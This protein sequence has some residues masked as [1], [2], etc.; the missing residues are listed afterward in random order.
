MAVAMK[1]SKRSKARSS[2]HLGEGSV[3]ASWRG[4]RTGGKGNTSSAAPRRR[5]QATR[6]GALSSVARRREGLLGGRKGVVRRAFLEDLQ[7]NF[8]KMFKG[9][10]SEA[11]RKKYQEQLDRINGLEPGMKRLSD[12]ELRQKTEDLKQRVQARVVSKDGPVDQQSVFTDD[13]VCEAFALVREGALRAI[14]LRPFDCQVIGG[15]V[16]HEGEIAEMGTG[17]GKTLVSVAPAFLNALCGRGV[18]VVTVND[19]LARRDAEWVGRV[20][21]FLGLQVGL[22]QSGGAG[23][24]GGQIAQA[25][26]GESVDPDIKRQA[27]QADI[28]YVT[29]SELGFDFLRDNLAAT[30]EE[31]VLRDNNPYYCII[32]EVDSILI[33]EARTPLI[34]SG[35]AEQPSSKYERSYQIAKALVEDTHYTVEE[36]RQTVL[37]TEEGY[38]AVESVL[39]VSDLYDPREQWISFISNAVKAKELQKKDV[40]YIVKGGEIVIIDEFTG[41]TMP[42]RRWGE[43]LHQAIEAKEGLEIQNETVTLASISYQN[44]FRAYQKK[45][46]MTGT[47]DTERAEFESIYN[48]EVSVVPTNKP[49]QRTDNPDVVFRSE[50]GKWNAVMIEIRRMHKT[51]RPV[52]VGTT[53]VEESERLAESLDEEGIP[54]QLLNAKP[55]NVQRESE[56][57][58]QSGRLGAVTIS[59][60]MAGRGTDILLGGNADFMARLKVRE[61]LFPQI[62]GTEDAERVGKSIVKG[63]K[64]MKDKQMKDWKLSEDLYPC[65]LSENTREILEVTAQYVTK[66]LDG[67]KVTELEASDMLSRACEKSSNRD[68][69]SELINEAYTAV[70]EEYAEVTSEEKRR[71]L[72]LGGLHVIGTERHESRRIDN[73]LRGRSGRQGDNGSTRF[74]LSLEDKIFR[75]FGGDRVKAMMSAF[76]VEDLPIESQML[77]SA[78]NEAQRKVEAYFY[79][80]RKQLFEYDEVLNIQREKVY[81]ERRRALLATEAQLSD[82]MIEYA[83]LTVNDVLEAN[84][85]PATPE[86]TWNLE[87]LAGKM[88]QYC[89]MLEELDE[90]VLRQ[91]GGYEGI[92]T[93]LQRRCVEAYQ[94]KVAEVNAVEDNLMAEAEQFFVLTQYDNLWKTHLQ[95]IKFLQT[96]VGLRGYAQRDPLTEFKLEGY[97]LFLEMMAQ[98]RRNCIYSVYQFKPE[99]VKPKAQKVEEEVKSS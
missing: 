96:A 11:C 13:I 31:L 91:Q 14:G 40:N 32:D 39:Q 9:D 77:T 34:I 44:F 41:R 25:A 5:L 90:Q 58:A 67:E 73:Q 92:R 89:Y 76:R 62:V 22:I 57:V 16:L 48:L 64:K 61:V 7:S 36:K 19:Y 82:Q 74:F 42:G 60:N 95:S 86:E 53:S 98:V 51:G 17:E 56:I 27:Y 54:Y 38:E 80:I 18:H 49:S 99:V 37:L 83:E 50:R 46:G 35:Q 20:H 15:L 79:D 87:G 52:L 81:S 33:D 85:D 8:N 65:E 28:T 47:A 69:V 10:P 30:K 23:L 88:K 97:N 68:K 3:L 21:T 24:V 45:A 70:C 26:E 84:L 72:E 29:N 93:Y 43:G 66:Q 59:T 78:L 55:E 2:C 12:E 4:T 75:I 71:V 63:K 6:Y 1:T 94:Q